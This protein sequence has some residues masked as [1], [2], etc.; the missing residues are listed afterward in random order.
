L[1]RFVYL[2]GYA[3]A[4]ETFRSGGFAAL[5]AAMKSRRTT[6]DVLHPERAPL[7]APEPPA[8]ERLLK[9]RRLADTDTLGEQAVVVLVA[10]GTGKDNLGLLAADGWV[11]DTLERWESESDATGTRG[12]TQWTTH[13][14]TETD[15]SDFVYA[16]ARVMAARFPA[17]TIVVDDAGRRRLTSAGRT[18]TLARKD[19]TVELRV[20]PASVPPSSAAPPPPRKGAAT[21]G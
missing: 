6:R 11:G 15:A 1:L 12:V 8:P 21:G 13:W 2:E 18:W 4:T 20:E 10:R 17:Q 5:D 9:G 19:L 14:A 3:Q 7:T 16:Y